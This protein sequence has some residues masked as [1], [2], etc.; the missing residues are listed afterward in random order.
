MCL[1]CYCQER[2]H[3]LRVEDLQGEIT[4]RERH[5]INLKED[6]SKLQTC[7]HH[8]NKEIDIKHQEIKKIKVETQ[9][10]MRYG[11]FQ[12]LYCLYYTLLVFSLMI[13][14]KYE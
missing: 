11:Q 2:D 3:A 5:I 4:Q 10:Q 12:L 14:M 7:I 13:P 9:N 8:L 6:T 1:F